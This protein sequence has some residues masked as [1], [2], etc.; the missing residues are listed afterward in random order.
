MRAI[1][2]LFAAMGAMVFMLLG[3]PLPWLLGSLTAVLV[4]AGLGWPH[5]P[6]AWLKPVALALLGVHVGTAIDAELLA[7]ARRWPL[8]LA[9]MLLLVAV[10]T[11]INT[12]YFERRAGL[13]RRTAMFA[14]VPG[15]QSVVLLTCDEYGADR[16]Q[17]LLG[18]ISRIVAVIYLV[19]LL[20]TQFIPRDP[21]PANAAWAPGL[22]GAMPEP[23]ALAITLL[24]GVTSWWLARRLRLP[25]PVLVG[26]ILGVGVIQ[27]LQLP[28]IDMPPGTL[29]VVQFCL[30]TSLGAYF[31]GISLRETRVMLGHGLV[32]MLMTLMLA[33]AMTLLMTLVTHH[34][35]AALFLA[36]VP[37]GLSEVVLLAA[38]LDVDP[39]FV[40]FHHLFRFIAIASLLP[41]LATRLAR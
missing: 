7:E 18:Q 36:F 31:V 6:P 19:P 13:D 26:P 37:G 33:V 15:A 21:E 23:T 20:L 25:L 16:R 1:T 29:L 4:A 11:F 41:W 10:T 12:W 40:V 14:A 5:S 22:D 27:L 38:S 8:T 39:A 9:G 32:A 3:V 28:V 34:D 17:V 2:L 35:T 30:G 24:A